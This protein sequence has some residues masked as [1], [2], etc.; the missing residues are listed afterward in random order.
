PVLVTAYELAERVPVAVEMG[1]QQGP[2][3]G[4]PRIVHG[5]HPIGHRRARASPRRPLNNPGSV[6]WV[7]R[8]GSRLIGLDWTGSRPS[9]AGVSR[10]RTCRGAWRG[11]SGDRP[12][13]VR[14][15]EAMPEQSA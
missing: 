14:A 11:V 10:W 15:G 2:V 7:V 3:V 6:G 9:A 5:L 13:P 8:L 4:Y 1:A 12:G